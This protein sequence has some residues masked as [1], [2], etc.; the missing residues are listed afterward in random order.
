MRKQRKILG[1]FNRLLARVERIGNRVYVYDRYNRRLGWVAKNGT[2]DNL[3]RKL[4]ADRDTRILVEMARNRS[5]I[6]P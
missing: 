4:S 5:M 6:L 1:R 3:G 2:F